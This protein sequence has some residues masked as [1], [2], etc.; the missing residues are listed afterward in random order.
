M[1]QSEEIFDK[2]GCQLSVGD[3][4]IYIRHP[5]KSTA[6]LEYGQI[7]RINRL[8]YT[9]M[10]LLEII[11]ENGADGGATVDPRHCILFSQEERCMRKMESGL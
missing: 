1:S 11:K 9:R 2:F 10:V 6:T 8:V 4:V 5:R 3:W 7:S